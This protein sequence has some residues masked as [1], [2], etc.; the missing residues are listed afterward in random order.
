MIES[1]APIVFAQPRARRVPI[2]IV[3][4]ILLVYVWIVT[5]GTWRHVPATTARYSDLAA[6]FLYGRLSLAV[7]PSAA[8][9]ALPNPYDPDAN[10]P[11]RELDLSLF[12]GRY[13]IYWG[14]VPAVLLAGACKVLGIDAPE[15]SDAYLGIA[16]MFGAAVFAT[17]IIF[18][19]RARLFPRQPPGAAALAALSVSLGAPALFCIARASVYETA[20]FSGQFFLLAGLCAAWFAMKEELRP[21]LLALSGTCWALSAGSRVSLPPA[22]A[23]MVAL[24]LWRLWRSGKPG[25]LGAACLMLPLLAGGAL[26]AW[27][28]HARFGSIIETGARYQL[29]GQNQTSLIGPSFLSIR[30]IF[31]NLCAYILLPPHT[32]STFPYFL[33]IDAK[34]WLRNCF[35]LWPDFFAEPLAGLLWTQFFLI[36]AV[37]AFTASPNAL[38][39]RRRP[40]DRFLLS[41]LTLTLLCGG[42]LGFLPSLAMDGVAMRYLLDGLPC[43]SILAA[44]GY[45]RFLESLHDRPRAARE[46]QAAARALV[47][48]QC[49]LGIL[50]AVSR[51]P[52]GFHHVARWF[53]VL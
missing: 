32:S 20:V 21:W 45:L 19:I 48:I 14:P 34:P 5:G 2:F 31:P 46:I 26:Q 4:L 6:G 52:A 10:A 36:L 16:F 27:Y 44:V 41:W 8:L 22:L 30:H 43:L 39:A 1:R 38:D 3:L 24:T 18:Q 47:G 51:S 42:F 11:Y 40:Q 9:L 53:P 49:V 7:Q 28:N 29:S 17:A 23:A 33:T 13:Y 50:L 25:A 37:L 35:T 15:I 12:N